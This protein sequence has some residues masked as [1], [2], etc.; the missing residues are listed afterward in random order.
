MLDVG[1]NAI[2]LTELKFCGYTVLIFSYPNFAK[3][4]ADTRYCGPPFIQL[5]K[6]F[7]YIL[8]QID[9]VKFSL[10]YIKI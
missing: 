7:R 4:M 5:L 10:D 2:L 8:K 3:K 9:V 1:Y 6:I